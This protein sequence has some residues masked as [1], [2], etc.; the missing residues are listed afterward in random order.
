M[1]ATFSVLGGFSNG[2]LYAQ[3]KHKEDEIKQGKNYILSSLSICPQFF[4]LCTALKMINEMV[5]PYPGKLAVKVA[6]QLT[7]IL[8]LITAPLCGLV[9]SGLYDPLAK[10]YNQEMKDPSWS[11]NVLSYIHLPENLSKR[12]VRAASFLAEYSGNILRVAVLASGVALIAL[13]NAAF[14]GALLAAVAYQTCDSKGF[15]PRRISLFMEIYMPI[16]ANIGMLLSGILIARVISAVCLV[17]YSPSINRF[18]H[19]KIDFFLRQKIPHILEGPTLKEIDAPIIEKTEMTYDQIQKIL[20]SNSSDFKIN[21]AHCSK[22][23]I[24]L[25]QLPCDSNFNKYLT[26]FDNIE[27]ESKYNYLKLKLKDDDRFLDF[28]SEKYSQV[29]KKILSKNIDTYIKELAAKDKM[30]PEKYVASWTRKQM[31]MLV[32]MLKGKRRVKGLQQD[33]DESIQLSKTILSHFVSL[34]KQ[35][36]EIDGLI[37]KLIVDRKCQIK[38]PVLNLKL[39]HVLIQMNVELKDDEGTIISL[40]DALAKLSDA[41][42]AKLKQALAGIKASNQIELEDSLVKF[43]VEGGDYCGR[44]I[45]RAA[46]ELLWAILESS[47]LKAAQEIENKQSGDAVQSFEI[48]MLQ[49]L[50]NHRCKIVQN[51]Y[52]SFS[53]H[54]NIPNVISQ[55]THGFDIYRLMLSLGIIPLSRYERNSMGLISMMYWEAFDIMR[56]HFYDKYKFELDKVVKDVGEIHFGMYIQQIINENKLLSEEEKEKLID[57]FILFN[58]GKWQPEETLKRFHRLLFVRL[59]VLIP[60]TGKIKDINEIEKTYGHW[61]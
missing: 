22:P 11:K 5:P 25:D 37:A 12:T 39:S 58:D 51:L 54:M 60:A 10:G 31:V 34:D 48:K 3:A 33:L 50:Q 13:G 26:L 4:V 9:K 17:G 36:G 46:N 23:A 32:E 45:K 57:K 14:G 43:A 29:D 42:Q 30:S 38:N 19:H 52:K 35:K 40:E 21:P 47:D 27:W 1:Q 24:D 7:P 28:L 53:N 41:N 6:C 44:G 49:A 2:Y 59:G 18:I 8:S 61:V 56:T 20:D 15:I 55:D 16:I